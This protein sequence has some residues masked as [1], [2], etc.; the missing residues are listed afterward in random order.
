MPPTV[1]GAAMASD[2]SKRLSMEL[3]P[4]PIRVR[5]R[6]PFRSDSTR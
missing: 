4:D 3:S 6:S 1:I 2:I 5:R